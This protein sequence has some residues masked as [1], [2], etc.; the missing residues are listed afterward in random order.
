MSLLRNWVL[1][2]CLFG[3]TPSLAQK[4]TVHNLTVAAQTTLFVKNDE[5]D[6]IIA[7]M[8]RLIAAKSYSWDV[9]CPTILF[10]RSGGVISN[11][12]LLTYGKYSEL[13]SNLA[14][15]VPAANVMV[16]SGIDCLGETA[17][18]C[19]VPGEEPLAAG[20]RQGYDAMIWLHERGHNVGL[21]HS[22]EAPADET[23]TRQDVALRFMFWTFGKGHVGK[24]ATEC[25]YFENSKLPSVTTRFAATPANPSNAGSPSYQFAAGSEKSD[26]AQ[27]VDPSAA[28]AEAGQK[29]GLTQAAFNV[30][31]FPWLERAPLEFIRVLHAEDLNSIRAIFNELP[32]QFWPQ[33]V[34]TLGFVGN[35]DDALI[36][37]RAL[38]YPM[39][40]VSAESSNDV[41]QQM[42][43]LLQTKLAAPKA[44]GI[45]AKRTNSNA[46]VEA[47]ISA[48]GIEQAERL[49]GP[50]SANSLSKNA[51]NGL[52]IA[53]TPQAN[54]FVAAL[55]NKENIVKV[56][57]LTQS[58]LDAL[59][60]FH[61]QVQ[62]YGVDSLF[63]MAP[64]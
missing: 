18:G 51:L 21:R 26:A 8:N 45:L 41:I 14:Q 63:K 10:Q 31:G 15:F 12:N 33:G 59:K 2:L 62:K 24:T 50:V 19:G 58:D 46:A 30:V 29:A 22:A 25:S 38:G 13:K 60:S 44:L 28:L 16:V 6:K 4:I 40:A 47:L 20:Q 1:V 56:A 23:N 49:I 35:G 54:Q 27:D 43:I 7:E 37:Q 48:A 42:R 53:D 9:A 3:G 55:F 61:E 17:M 57:P 36:I 11:D 5:V 64:Q 34:Q 39:P 52:A 32:N